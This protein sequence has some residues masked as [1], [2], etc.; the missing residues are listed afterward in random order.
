MDPDPNPGGPKTC[1]PATLLP[2]LYLLPTGRVGGK[3]GLTVSDNPANTWHQPTDERNLEN[4]FL[5]IVD[6]YKADKMKL[7]LIMVIFAEKVCGILP[8]LWIRTT[9]VADPGCLSRILIFTH[10]GSRIQKPQ[11]K[12]G[13]KKMFVKPFFVATNFTK[14]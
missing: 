10:P 8:I 6:A 7:E 14:L 12:G 1:G 4:D 13:L 5:K 11:L 3:N 2:S 9:S